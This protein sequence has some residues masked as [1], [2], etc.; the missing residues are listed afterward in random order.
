MSYRRS[1]INKYL[2]YSTYPLLFLFSKLFACVLFI[3][4]FL[5]DNKI[6]NSTHFSNIYTICIGNLNFG[7]SGKTPLT[8]YLIN[9]L[10]PHFKI[11][12]LSRGYGRKTK[13]FRIVEANDNYWDC[14]DEPLMYKLKYPDVLITICENRVL[15]IQNI[16]QKYPD[17]QIILLD[18]ALQHRKIKADLNILLSEYQ[19]PFF[20]ENIFP[21]GN[22]RDLKSRSKKNDL[23][24]LS[25]TPENINDSELQKFLSETKNYF[26]KEV[27]FNSIEYENLYSFNSNKTMDVYKELYN[28]NCILLTGIANPHPLAR[29]IKEYAQFFYHLK[30]PD[31]YN[32]TQKEINLI[33]KMYSEWQSKNPNTIIITTEKDLVRL[34]P[35]IHTQL[36]LPIFVAPIKIKF[37]NPSQQNFNQKIFDYVRSNSKNSKLY[38]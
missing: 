15:G 30:F 36:N 31:H 6:L 3:R 1:N 33:A 28:Y 20:R 4:H 24:I 5:Y 26:Q 10:K 14:G 16:L 21:L 32:F 23:L 2:Y 9:L 27:Y 11:A 35:F 34:K 17:V 37:L 38:S 19:N 12:V 18:D 8:E 25:K 29:I 13:G 7:G 22:L